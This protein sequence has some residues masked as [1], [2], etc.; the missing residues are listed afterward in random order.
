MEED[1][2]AKLLATTAV[3][4]I[5]GD[6]ISWGG[7]VDGEPLPA[8]A[9]HLISAPRDYT[10]RGQTRLVGSRVQADCWDGTWLGAKALSRVVS[11]TLSGLK[12]GAFTG[13]F[14]LDERHGDEKGEGASGPDPTDFYR[15]SLDLQVRHNEP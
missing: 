12:E 6:R 14:I 10:L 1:L 3:T 9:L 7:R 11:A 2:L 4:A 8:I 15:T 5:V 13:I